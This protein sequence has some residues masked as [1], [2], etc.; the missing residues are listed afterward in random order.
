MRERGGVA[1]QCAVKLR[2]SRG[3]KI[4]SEKLHGPTFILKGYLKLSLVTCPVAMTPAITEGRGSIFITLSRA[5][6]HRV[7]SVYVDADSTQHE[8]V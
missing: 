5:T 2:L 4:R 7:E 3:S 1:T 8:T 6:G